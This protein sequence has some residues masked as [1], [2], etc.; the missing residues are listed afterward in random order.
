MTLKTDYSGNFGTAMSSVHD[1][2]NAFVVSNSATISAELVTNAN[3]GSRKFTVSVITSFETANLRLK[4]LHMETYL[5]GI[6]SGLSDEDIY[7]YEC[8]PVLN[9]DDQIDTYI[10]FVFNFTYA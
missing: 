8:T 9:T 10:D 6:L 4:G 2:G 7:G 5:D 1:A 3:A